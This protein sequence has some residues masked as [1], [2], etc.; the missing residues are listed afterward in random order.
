MSHSSATL[1]YIRNKAIENL[2]A[3]IGLD[4]GV[5]QESIDFKI[6][7]LRDR[8]A[9]IEG[10]I[11]KYMDFQSKFEVKPSNKNIS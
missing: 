11:R 4:D 5:I 8:I 2:E 10:E 7:T 3:L 6:K 9:A 1:P